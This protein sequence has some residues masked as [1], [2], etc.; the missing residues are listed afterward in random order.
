MSTPYEDIRGAY[1]K[2]GGGGMTWEELVGW[3]LAD[4][5]AYVVK[6]PEY[7]IMGRAVNK[8]A[9]VDDIRDLRVRFAP[10]NCDAWF[11]YAFSGD[12]KKA[13]A[14]LPYELPWLAWERFGDPEKELRFISAA[15]IHRHSNQSHALQRSVE[16]DR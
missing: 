12:M 16:R 11:L 14:A 7:F 1:L 6:T 4:P 10:Q 15:S 9:N 5:F 2:Q 13:W 3:H 8:S